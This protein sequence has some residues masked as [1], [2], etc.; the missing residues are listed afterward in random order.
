MLDIPVV[1]ILFCF[2]HGIKRIGI[3][4]LG[5]RDKCWWGTCFVCDQVVVKVVKT[6]FFSMF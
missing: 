5:W 6:L 1:L 2:V 3:E 4:L